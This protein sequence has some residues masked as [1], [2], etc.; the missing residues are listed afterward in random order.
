MSNEDNRVDFEESPA[1]TPELL[2][3]DPKDWKQHDLYA[4]LGLAKL[5][6]KATPEQIKLARRLTCR[7]CVAGPQ[8]EDLL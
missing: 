5:R 7:N 4:I 2:A 8:P 3:L 6:Y 1:E